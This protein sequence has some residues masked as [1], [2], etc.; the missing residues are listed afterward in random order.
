MSEALSS[1]VMTAVMHADSVSGNKERR[2]GEG[3]APAEG[4]T[5]IGATKAATGVTGATLTV[6]AVAASVETCP[7][8]AP[9]I[10]SSVSG[11]GAGAV[12]VPAGFDWSAIDFGLGD[13]T[14]SRK[15]SSG[16]WDNSEAVRVAWAKR[17]RRDVEQER[18]SRGAVTARIETKFRM[19]R[20]SSMELRAQCEKR[21]K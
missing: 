20:T 12:L 16:F 2:D 1:W 17:A 15:N 4:A 14:K 13:W 8:R 3:N 5:V 10:C 7:M 6:A 9:S 18:R 11:G 21:R 19:G